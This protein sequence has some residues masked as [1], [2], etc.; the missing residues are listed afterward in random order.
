MDYNYHTHT[1]R[2][3][4]AT[5]S[6]EEYIQT[7]IRGGIK[8][9]GF[10]DHAP[11]IF[12]DGYESGFR[13]PMAQAG[14]YISELRQLREKYQEKIELHIGFEME[15]YPAH[16]DAML[17]N[18][19]DLGAEYLILGQHFLGNEHP[20]GHHAQKGSGNE[21]MLEEYVSTVIAGM[22]TGAFTYVAHPDIFKY[23]GDMEIYRREMGR[24]CTVSRELDVPLEINFLGIRQGRNYPDEAFWELAGQ[25]QCPVTFGFDAHE[26][27]SAY[28]SVS[29]V[30]A[31]ALVEKYRLNYIGEPRLVPIQK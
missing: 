24:I 27:P 19:K 28:D 29:L 14:E 21:A 31:K 6:P 7:A 4:H 15:Y 22:R 2:C 3:S 12:P 1:P 17:Q 13:V 18:V 16:F 10:S 5:G 23:A 25:E 11:W 8:R 30:K 26:I 20:N 9:M